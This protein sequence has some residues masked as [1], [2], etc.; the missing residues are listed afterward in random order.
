ML[1]LSAF[2]FYG[3]FLSQLFTSLL[4]VCVLS[5]PWAKLS[6]QG[7]PKRMTSARGSVTQIQDFLNPCVTQSLAI[8]SQ[9][10]SAPSC[11]V[12]G[13]EFLFNLKINVTSFITGDVGH[14][15]HPGIII[16]SMRV[17]RL[18]VPGWR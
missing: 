13:L 17:V 11:N 14:P 3:T 12:G 15:R 6:H 10:I 4:G 8:L 16:T 18:F 2:T 1:L 9:A 5:I 7:L